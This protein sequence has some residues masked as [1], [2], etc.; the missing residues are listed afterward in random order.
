MC[1]S[2]LFHMLHYRQKTVTQFRQVIFYAERQLVIIMPRQYTECLKL[3]ELFCQG[4]L[5]DI[6]DAA[7]QFPKTVYIFKCNI[8]KNFY[9]PFASKYF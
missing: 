3:S 1:L 7:T 4:G 8:I 2:P 5:C 6:T 9:F